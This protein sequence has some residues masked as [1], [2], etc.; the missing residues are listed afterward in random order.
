M[1]IFGRDEGITFDEG[2]DARVRAAEEKNTAGITDVHGGFLDRR[3][4]QV[5]IDFLPI[6]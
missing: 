5:K 2:E 3:S 1:E 4:L 6:E